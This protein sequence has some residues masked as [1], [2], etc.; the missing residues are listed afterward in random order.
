VLVAVS[1]GADSTALLLGLHRIAP[2]LGIDLSA[3]HL[4]HG[5]RGVEADEDQAS[6]TSLC[7]RLGVPLVTARWNARERMRRRRLS[8]EAGLR[9]LRRE[10]LQAAARR[11]GAD[12]IALAHTADDQLETVLLRLLRGTGLRGL[13]GMSARSSIWIRPLL[14]A[15]RTEIE[16]DLR[17][18]RQAWR[19]DASNRSLAFARNRVRHLAVPALCAVLDP[20]NPAR[21]RPGLARRVTA[22]AREVRSAR[23]VLGDGLRR[24][25]AGVARIQHHQIALD[26]RQVRSYPYALR[27]LL[28][29]DLWRALKT[30]S[31]GLTHRHLEALEGL[32]DSHRGGASV[33]LPHGYRAELDH[34]N[35]TIGPARTAVS[36]AT[37]RWSPPGGGR[38]AGGEVASRWLSAAE[39]R[40]RLASKRAGEEF[41]A[42]NEV[43]GPLELRPGRPDESFVPFGRVREQRLG[44]FLIRQRVSRARRAHPLVLADSGGI[45]WVIGVRRSARAPVTAETRKALWVQTERHD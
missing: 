2:E 30:P 9:T 21:A 16:A 14:E 6:V 26:S 12:A 20:A 31:E 42:A 32:L 44:S 10:F 19:E 11:C 24:L 29:R 25:L 3:A 5:L 15:T 41:F 33:A 8:G 18:A 27:R 40:R 39:A 38:W 1:G 36:P 23:R 22:E 4:H 37:V 35:I 34:G 17:A 28:L 45:L 43:K 13:G 7:A